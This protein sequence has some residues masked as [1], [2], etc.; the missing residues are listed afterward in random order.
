MGGCPGPGTSHPAP[1][2]TSGSTTVCSAVPAFGG[3]GLSAQQRERFLINLDETAE[4]L[5]NE[6]LFGHL[7]MCRN[8]LVF[9]NSSY[10]SFL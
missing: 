6:G 4:H 8:I 10:L 2:T 3:S 9:N 5:L 7:G 1:L